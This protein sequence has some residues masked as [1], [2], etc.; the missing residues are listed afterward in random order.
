MRIRFLVLFA[1]MVAVTAQARSLYWERL[2][3]N[4]RLDREGRLQS[5]ETQTIVFDGDWN[6]GERR[7]NVRAGQSLEVTGLTRIDNGREIPLQPGDLSQVDQYKM[8]DGNLLRWR[9][10]LPSDPPFSNTA[11]TYRIDYVLGGVVQRRGS[12]YRLS[13]DFVFPDRSGV[14]KHF[15]MHLELDPAWGGQRVEAAR[16]DLQPGQS[17]VVTRDLQWHGAG[18]PAGVPT[19]IPQPALYGIALALLAGLVWE[20][21][22]FVAHEKA[23][24][25]L[26]PLPDPSTVDERWLEQ[27]LFALSPEVAGASWD[28]DVGAPE[29]AA[30]LARM[31]VEKKIS[32]E[33][34]TSEGLFGG[35]PVLHMKLLVDRRELRGY[36]H[37]LVSKLF[38]DGRTETDTEAVQNHY[39]STGL[40]LAAAIKPDI[41]AE[42]KKLPGWDEKGYKAPFGRDSMLALSIIGVLIFSAVLGNESDRMYAAGTII[43]GLVC[44]TIAAIAAGINRR[45]ITSV[46]PRYVLVGVFL[47]PL[48]AMTLSYI[49]SA[50]AFLTHLVTTVAIAGWALAVVKIALDVMRIPDAPGTIAFR[51]G[52]A[53]ARQYFISQL[54]STAPKLRDEWLPYILGFG[55]GKNVDAWFRSVGSQTSAIGTT[56]SSSSF[57]SSSSIASSSSGWTGGGGAFGGAGATG[58]WTVA[59]GALAAGVSAPS[60]S[61]SGGG[62]GGGSSSGGGGGGGW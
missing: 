45:K 24:G 54:N 32:S 6:G 61:S 18:S 51:R 36:E 19:A 12:D 50:G 41:E 56:H 4:A 53:T 3:V 11:I 43:S 60:S 28:G 55:L 15:T 52:I 22:Q 30:V 9:S 13:H 38:F 58:A 26:A 29:V 2:D 57:G 37:E 16:E 1:A 47:L 49:L 34:K 39:K 27:H 10:R 25:R 59:A 33:V 31:A 20:V 62:G 7:F 17:M 5:A 14:I 42:L 35:K 23:A 21:M 48:L 40:D 44:L 46:I 8:F